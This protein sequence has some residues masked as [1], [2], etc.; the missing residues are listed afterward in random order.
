M[1]RILRN[2]FLSSRTKFERR[3]PEALDWDESEPE[4]VVDPETPE[5][6]LM[7]RCNSQLEEM[8]YPEIAQIL[9]I[10][11]GTVMSRLARARKVVR[12]SLGSTPGAPPSKHWSHQIETHERD[13]D[14]VIIAREFLR[15]PYWPLRAA[16]E[17]GPANVVAYAISEELRRKAHK[18]ALR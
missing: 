2:T 12:E 4:L 16:R 14:A 8:S 13:A 5:A 1:L 7:N 17:L 11:T 9:S 6:I 18:L 15:D 3:M 10:R